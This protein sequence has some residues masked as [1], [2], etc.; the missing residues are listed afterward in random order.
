MNVR[1]ANLIF[2][3]V[4]LAGQAGGGL[5]SAGKAQDLESYRIAVDV[6]L[7]VLH[8]A[9]RDRKGRFVSDLREQDFEVYE[10]GVRQTIRLFQYE[11]TPVTVGLVVDH[12]R[13]MRTRLA[14]VT[15]AAAG[16]FARFSNTEDQIFVVNFNENVSLGL[17]ATILFTN[18]YAALQDAIANAPA[19]GMTALYDAIVQGLEH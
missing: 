1:R 18:S 15:A 5:P 7:V 17:P 6:D 2:L 8:P 3:L 10:D 4:V 14:Q 19:A 12:S 16:T 11:D 13:S 9:V